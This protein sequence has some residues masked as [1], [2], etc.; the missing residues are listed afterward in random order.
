MVDR[1]SRPAAVL[2]D[3]DGTLLDSEPLWSAAARHLA[4]Q[5]GRPWSTFDDREIVGWSVPAVASYLRGRGVG[6][7]ETWIVDQLHALVGAAM[8]GTLPWRDG[9]F[10]LLTLLRDAEV[11]VALVTMTY[12]RLAELVVRAAPSGT[13]QALVTGD[14][15]TWGKPHPEA[16]R[17]AAR[18]LGADPWRCVAVEDSPTGVASALGSGAWTYAVDPSQPISDPHAQAPRLQRV[19]GL[20]P[21]VAELR[22]RLGGPAPAGV[23]AGG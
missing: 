1:L 5:Q 9:A 18:L 23:G 19:D 10:E 4:E 12:R 7:D 8:L 20:G 17:T 14:D 13:I 2:L 3:L 21:V 15:V 6:Q 22:V 11:P 16:Y